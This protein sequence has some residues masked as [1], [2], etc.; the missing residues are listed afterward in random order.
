MQTKEYIQLLFKIYLFISPFFRI[1]ELVGVR[2]QVFKR[3]KEEE[4]EKKQKFLE[5]SFKTL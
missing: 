2:C 5:E 4:K 1:S 3:L